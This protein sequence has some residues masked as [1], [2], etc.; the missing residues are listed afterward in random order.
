MSSSYDWLVQHNDKAVHLGYYTHKLRARTLYNSV[1]A[2]YRESSGERV[3]EA[4]FTNDGE[5][6]LFADGTRFAL[7][8]F[9]S[10][11]KRTLFLDSSDNP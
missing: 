9:L 6:T 5:E 4:V 8:G 1:V 7:V 3:V 2:A 10:R 11:L